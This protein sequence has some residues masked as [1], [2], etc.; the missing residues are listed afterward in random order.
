MI[1]MNDVLNT[2]RGF[3]NDRGGDAKSV[4]PSTRLLGDGYVDSF[5]LIELIATLEKSLGMKLEDGALI[6]EDFE[7]VETLFDRLQAID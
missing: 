3:I 6:P 7:T 4:G 2:V 1:Q 5:A